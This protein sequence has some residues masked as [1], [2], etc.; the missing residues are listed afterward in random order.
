MNYKNLLPGDIILTVNFKDEDNGM[1]G[2]FNHSSI[3]TKDGI[4]ES[5]M[6][7]I[8]SVIKSDLVEFGF[9][10]KEYKV[11]RFKDGVYGDK[12]A[13]QVLDLVGRKYSFWSS[14]LF[15]WRLRGRLN[16]VAAV[17]LAYKQA[18]DIDF[19]WLIPDHISDDV[20]LTN[21]DISV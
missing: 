12:I 3:F 21:I 7:P 15:N 14:V 11:M 18:T 17:R 20:R 1:P 4:V 19:G 16:C 2:Y 13:A 10:Y 5:Q 8:K 6:A 9:R